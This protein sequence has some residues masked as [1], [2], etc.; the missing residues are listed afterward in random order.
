MCDGEAMREEMMPID[1]FRDSQCRVYSRLKLISTAALLGASFAVVMLNMSFNVVFRSMVHYE[2]HF[3]LDRA[4]SATFTRVFALKFVN[5][6]ILQ[7]LV[8]SQV[9][10]DAVGIFNIQGS[11]EFDVSWYTEKLRGKFSTR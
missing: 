9:F 7:L 10:I 11:R 5:M 6:G 1:V 3:S 4:A 8:N 2:K